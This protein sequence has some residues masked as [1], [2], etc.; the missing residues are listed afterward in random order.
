LQQKNGSLG[1][2]LWLS[3][4]VVENEKI[5]EIERTRVRSPPQATS[6]KK[7][8]FEVS[9]LNGFLS[10]QKSSAPGQFWDQ[11]CWRLGT[12]EARAHAQPSF[13]EIWLPRGQFLKEGRAETLSLGVFYA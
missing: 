13:T 3:G 7:W 9:F 1:E 11:L 12:A 5:N 2:P 4:K 6:L 10:L 8:Q